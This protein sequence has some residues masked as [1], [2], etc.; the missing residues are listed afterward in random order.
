MPKCW[1]IAYFLIKILIKFGYTPSI[2]QC[3][4]WRE[5]DIG[6]EWF[7]KLRYCWVK[8]KPFDIVL[9]LL[10]ITV[11]I[12][13]Y[14]IYCF[15]FFLSHIAKVYSPLS[16]SVFGNFFAALHDHWARSPLLT[17]YFHQQFMF[18]SLILL[19]N[20]SDFI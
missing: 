4:C 13:F 10:E 18:I 8:L 9:T 5:I 17:I 3:F 7:I 16:E 20:T 6:L 2:V 15:Q 14:K 12:F 19:N 11:S 1:K